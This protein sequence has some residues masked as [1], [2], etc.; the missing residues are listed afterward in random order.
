[1]DIVGKAIWQ[2]AAGDTGRDY[3]EICLRWDV[4]LNGRAMR[5]PG[6]SA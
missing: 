5:I 1:M 2:Q 4:I 6:H 3:A